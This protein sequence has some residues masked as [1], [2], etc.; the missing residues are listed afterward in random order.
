MIDYN[1]SNLVA[2]NNSTFFFI[3]NSSRIQGRRVSLLAQIEDVRRTRA[4]QRSSRKRHGGSY[5]QELVTVAIVGYTNAVCGSTKI[6][7]LSN[8]S[9]SLQIYLS[10]LQT[11][12]VTEAKFFYALPIG[13]IYTS[14]RTF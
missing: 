8:V 11:K 14:E 4:I 10:F 13:E 3:H 9:L 5:G 6:A 12:A 7:L 1:L 2:H